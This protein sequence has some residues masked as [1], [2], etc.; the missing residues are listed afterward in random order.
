MPIIHIHGVA[1]RTP[2][3]LAQRE[4]MLSR[5]I[6]DELKHPNVPGNV[7]ILRTFWGDLGATFAWNLQACPRPD[8]LQMMGGPA[9]VS[10]A[11]QAQLMAEFGPELKGVPLATPAAVT[12]NANSGLTTGNTNTTP[13][14][15]Q[16]KTRLRDLNAD[17]LSDLAV[18]TVLTKPV[19]EPWQQTL[20][21][22]AADEVAQNPTTFAKLAAE[23]NADAETALLQK[24]IEARYTELERDRDGLLLQGPG[25]FG[26]LKDRIKEAMTRADQLDGFVLTR[27]LNRFRPALNSG[28]MLFFGDVF[29]YLGRRGT[30][31][32]PGEITQRLLDQ[33]EKA[34]DLQQQRHGEPIVL[35]SHS[36]GG[37][38][39]YDVLTYFLP[40]MPQYQHIKVDFWCATA[41]QVGI[42][43]E[44]KLF[45]MS[46]PNFS[47]AKGN[48][49]TL[50]ASAQLGHW[51][52]V[53]DAND[54]LSYTA[55]PIFDNIDDESYD[56]GMSVIS[57]HGGYLQQPSFYRK[58]ATKLR[59]HLPADWF[60]P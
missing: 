55:R 59:T 50:P 49:M 21:I 24:L 57:A 11:E 5:Y 46:S 19:T 54:Y 45:A 20:A 29:T 43:E 2:D 1:T 58:F 16:P 9:A 4:A 10:P 17:Q 28:A 53:W 12:A 6:S 3:D 34:Y 31:E 40:N 13:P 41:S 26:D 47:Q 42:F 48:K 33:L 35:L 15:A 18:T 8:P 36:M 44:M 30:P 37:Q 22:I 7:P 23:P 39:V 14:P 38:I 32:Q 60:R 27:V 51:W 25:W 52:N 56:S